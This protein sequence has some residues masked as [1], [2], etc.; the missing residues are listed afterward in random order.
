MSIR[1]TQRF[2]FKSVSPSET[3]KHLKNLQRN[4]SS[5]IDDLPP[6]LL[7]DVADEIAK[8][9]SSFIINK[10]LSTTT[11]PSLWK[12][13]KV[14]PIHK[15]GSKTDCNNYRPI[16]VLP[17]LSKIMEQFV[18]RQLSNYLEKY[19]LLKSSQ[20]GFLPRRLTE[21]VCTLLVDGIRKN[22]DNRLLIG[23]IFLDLSK[24]FDTVSH[25]YVLEKLPPSEFKGP[26]LHGLR[27]TFLTE[28]QHV[29]YN[30]C[31][32]NEVPV[33]RG[34]PQGSNLCLTLFLLHLNGINNCL[35]HCK[36]IKYADDTVIYTT[37]KDFDMI[38]RK[39]QTDISE[40]NK[41]LTDSDLSL[42][43]KKGKNR[44]D[45]FWHLT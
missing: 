16:S 43:L 8:P 37:G 30:G 9:S 18:Q 22:M 28:K 40:V 3:F 42:N 31:L 33:H 41:R 13:S 17:C 2:S 45:D 4:K 19:N 24:V 10:S 25:S 35:H 6:N 29:L 7:K 15:S 38:Q 21:L 39:L 34:V 1:T 11:I 23:V 32:L 44:V 27:T 36:I 20:F 26:N 12:S 14:T 5:G